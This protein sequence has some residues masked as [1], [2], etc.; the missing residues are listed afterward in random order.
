M[1][2][3]LF[4]HHQEITFLLSA[5]IAVVVTG[6]VATL[7]RAL[8]AN[9]NFNR[10]TKKY[11]LFVDMISDA[12]IRADVEYRKGNLAHL[13]ERA[14]IEN[15]DVRLQWVIERAQE[16]IDLLKLPVSI[17][18]VADIVEAKVFNKDK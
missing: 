5:A 2:E 16:Y 11:G 8:V 10:F 1:T 4:E 6:I 7:T 12:V 15:R 17:D 13:E 9:E 18:Q 14:K 3:F